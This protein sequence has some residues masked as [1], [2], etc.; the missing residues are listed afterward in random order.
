[1][2]PVVDVQRLTGTTCK[3][4][5]EVEGNYKRYLGVVDNDVDFSSEV[6]AEPVEDID[7]GFAQGE[8]WGT[9]GRCFFSG[10]DCSVIAAALQRLSK[11]V[12]ILVT[13]SLT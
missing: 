2:A 4:V 9:R 8:L 10:T 1:M 12:Q 3:M 13:S 7:D 11:T 5:I 6:L